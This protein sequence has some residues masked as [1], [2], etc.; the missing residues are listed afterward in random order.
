MSIHAGQLFPLKITDILSDITTIVDD[1]H[2]LG[3]HLKMPRHVL[4]EIKTDNPKV[5]ARKEQMIS[6]WISGD[7]SMKTPSCWWSLVKAIKSMG[8]NLIV[9]KIEKNHRK[10]HIIANWDSGY[11]YSPY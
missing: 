11:S 7:S 3:I 4:E 10:W 5:V 6:K 8:E 1:W 2:S 9:K